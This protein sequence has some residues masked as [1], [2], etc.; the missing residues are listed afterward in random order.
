MSD[1]YQQNFY[2]H[3]IDVHHILTSDEQNSAGNQEVTRSNL[4]CWALFDNN[5]V[6]LLY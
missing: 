4:T 6:P 5:V 2:R 1:Y 3:V